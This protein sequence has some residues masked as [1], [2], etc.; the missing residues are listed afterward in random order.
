MI[1]RLNV[2]GGSIIS[3]NAGF[4]E[5]AGDLS[6][7]IKYNIGMSGANLL[8]DSEVGH[9]VKTTY[10]IVDTIRSF[11]AFPA[12]DAVKYSENAFFRDAIADAAEEA[13]LQ[14]QGALGSG[15]NAPTSPATPNGS[16]LPSPGLP[17]STSSALQ[18]NTGSAMNSVSSGQ[19][20]P[21][22]GADP[23]TVL[24][25]ASRAQLGQCIA[26]SQLTG[27]YADLY[28]GENA[29]MADIISA[30]ANS[31]EAKLNFLNMDFN[32]H[33]QV[34]Q[35]F[36]N[37]QNYAQ[38]T[39]LR[40]HI[41]VNLREAISGEQEL[42]ILLH[43]ADKETYGRYI[44]QFESAIRDNFSREL[45]TLQENVQAMGYTGSLTDVQALE[46]F[47]ATQTHANAYQV[48]SLIEATNGQINKVDRYILARINSGDIDIHEIIKT[49]RFNGVDL[50]AKA[51]AA[52][53]ALNVYAN[54]DSI[55]LQ[56][57]NS[58]LEKLGYHSS[59]KDINL[60]DP[61][62]LNK[63][64]QEF[65][66]ALDKAGLSSVNGKKLSN[67]TM[68]ELRAIDL[69]KIDPKYHQALKTLIG[70]QDHK[71][72]LKAATRLKQTFQMRMLGWANK[73]FKDSDLMKGINT[74]RSSYRG[75]KMGVKI[76]SKT[77]GRLYKYAFKKLFPKTYTKLATHYT[78]N[79]KKLKTL[80]NS[81][82]NPARSRFAAKAAQNT[83]KMAAKAANAAKNTARA[84]RAVQNARQAVRTARHAA[85]LMRT[86]TQL[87]AKAGRLAAHATRTAMGIAQAGALG[88]TGAAAA[89]AGA[90]SAAAGTAA[91]AAGGAAAGGAAAGAGTAVAASG[92]YGWAAAGAGAA[93][94]LYVILWVIIICLLISI[95]VQC[96]GLALQFFGYAV[97]ELNDSVIGDIIN[98]ISEWTWPWEA[99]EEDA[100]NVLNATIRALLAEER[101]LSNPQNYMT[102][103]D[104][105]VFKLG[106]YTSSTTDNKDVKWNYP[107]MN[108][109]SITPNNSH[110]I[111]TDSDG[112]PITQYS[113]IKRVIS[114]AHAYTYPI[115]Y[116]TDLNNFTLYATGL[117]HNL[118]KR[119]FR[120]KLSFC[121]G[122]HNITYKC[123]LDDEDGIFDFTDKSSFYDNVV[124][125][126][127]VFYLTNDHKK[128][129]LYLQGNEPDRFYLVS[130]E[131]VSRVENGL[132]CKRD[133]Y[134][135]VTLKKRTYTVSTNSYSTWKSTNSAKLKDYSSR[136]TELYNKNELK[137][138]TGIGF[139][140][141]KYDTRASGEDT[142]YYRS[143]PKG[144]LDCLKYGDYD[145]DAHH[146]ASMGMTG[147][148]KG[149]VQCSSSELK[150]CTNKGSHTWKNTWTVMVTKYDIN[151][152]WS[153]QNASGGISY[154]EHTGSDACPDYVFNNCAEITYY[155]CGCG[156]NYGNFLEGNVHQA[157]CRV[158][159]NG[160]FGIGSG[161]KNAYTK[162]TKYQC[163]GHEEEEARS[164]TITSTV[165][166]GHLKCVRDVATNT[167]AKQQ[168]YYCPEHKVVYCEGHPD[169]SLTTKITDIDSDAIYN[170][171]WTYTVEYKLLWFETKATFTPKKKAPDGQIS[172]ARKDWA[173]WN[174]ASREYKETADLIYTSDWY[175]KY[176][177]GM[178][179]LIG[180]TCSPGE[181]D[182]LLAYWKVNQDFND[183]L[184]QNLYNALNAIGKVSYYPGDRPKKGGYH[185]DN[186]FGQPADKV[187]YDKYQN[188]LGAHG[189][190]KL[191]LADWIYRTTNKDATL[192]N[193]Q[194]P[195]TVTY[196]DKMKVTSKTPAGSLIYCPQLKATGVL[197]GKKGNGVHYIGFQEDAVTIATG[198]D[199]TVLTNWSN[200]LTLN[201][202]GLTWYVIPTK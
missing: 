137:G 95:A 131:I 159:S 161:W 158:Y 202:N 17:E 191:Y 135:G 163:L 89:S 136:F 35:Y 150:N 148:W 4:S 175:L 99:S 20:N 42:M 149:V 12:A 154:Y 152:T 31:P 184:F 5:L 11:Y 194:N 98:W 153:V 85:R 169:F 123:N 65:T 189:L 93:G 177:I 36:E 19:V 155:T 51:Q 160:F 142:E 117:Y 2:D 186:K 179:D 183:P 198:K 71:E 187:I 6:H 18:P 75:V 170:Q 70:L 122:C 146:A 96:I 139:S 171:D 21:F 7:K 156:A 73:V 63:R 105:K 25:N 32:D 134:N 174:D 55:A 39:N 200:W 61:V 127:K 133:E 181:R 49:G 83:T 188:R 172:L 94:T 132:G 13:R 111:Y 50:D 180:A 52:F 22:A 59:V 108:T 102:G 3:P 113:T 53:K 38:Q 115:E 62:Q 201:S 114:M 30:D 162:H 118:N 166:L 143:N 106:M 76:W 86:Q 8:G 128:N 80:I 101:R 157:K 54:A 27:F 141:A 130:G 46:A 81:I 178:N 28:N 26:G 37:I 182:E 67:M 58:I 44:E 40:E 16:S 145:W 84:G 112:N 199:G 64:I 168:H 23:N 176:G 34:S 116:K 104:G 74:L 165:C 41:G 72:T 144:C 125:P 193:L 33:D 138:G 167:Q 57:H 87:I 197:L 185:L 120:V 90:A 29:V 15:N 77:A 140:V 196:N 66:E 164:E 56:H 14:R 109:S 45:T 110:A 91:V 10:D 47:G 78:A 100:E 88:T 147:F 173:G 190:D 107:T 129:G 9:V 119:T 69:S 124:E 43:T 68:K 79:V 103:A 126:G 24:N 195:N 97:Q 192:A 92:P 60:S 151:T 121:D 82:K 1:K 48:Q